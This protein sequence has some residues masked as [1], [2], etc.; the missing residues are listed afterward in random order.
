LLLEAFRA[1]QE[2]GARWVTLEVRRSN[3]AAQSLYGKFGFL[4]KGVRP[5]YYSDTGEDALIL[6]AE[7]DRIPPDGEHEP[8][9]ANKV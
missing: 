4:V 1:S 2:E 7:L 5:G 8:E 6:W 9:W 3:L